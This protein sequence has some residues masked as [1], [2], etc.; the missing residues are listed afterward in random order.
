MHYVTAGKSQMVT[1]C[2]AI[3]K[4]TQKCQLQTNG[5]PHRTIHVHLFFEKKNSKGKTFL[6]IKITHCTNTHFQFLGYRPFSHY[7]DLAG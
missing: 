1:T 3:W 4:N 7:G 5:F 2:V 6:H